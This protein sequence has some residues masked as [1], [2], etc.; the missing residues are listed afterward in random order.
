VLR[1]TH[2]HN[3]SL[4]FV[5]IKVNFERGDELRH[6]WRVFF[7][8]P[9]LEPKLQASSFMTNCFEDC[10]ILKSEPLSFEQCAEKLQMFLDDQEIQQALN[11]G[12][13][14]TAHLQQII[15]ELKDPENTPKPLKI[16]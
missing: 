13:E 6:A 11:L 7:W 1:R 16:D 8:L 14:V 9:N 4:L 5:K 12:V 15:H 2:S 3:F 10:K